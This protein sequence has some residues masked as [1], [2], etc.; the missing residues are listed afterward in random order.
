MPAKVPSG[1]VYE[2]VA[3]AR[4]AHRGFSDPPR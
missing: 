2:A 4:Y 3:S 1:A